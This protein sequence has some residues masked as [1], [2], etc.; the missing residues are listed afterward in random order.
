MLTELSNFSNIQNNK[1]L[2]GMK[3]DRVYGI[4]WIMNRYKYCTTD[5]FPTGM[6]HFKF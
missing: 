3:Y 2:S 6:T 1:V 5:F 4:E